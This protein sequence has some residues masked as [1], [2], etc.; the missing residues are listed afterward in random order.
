MF[1]PCWGL[2]CVCVA[3]SVHPFISLVCKIDYKCAV[4]IVGSPT[5]G[6][7][8]IAIVIRNRKDRLINADSY[9]HI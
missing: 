6:H 3:S 2:V 8:L 7:A 5:G 1:T 9:V 4:L